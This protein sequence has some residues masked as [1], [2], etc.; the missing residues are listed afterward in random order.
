M[1]HGNDRSDGLNVK[2]C[3]GKNA[4]ISMNN[5]RTTTMKGN[6]DNTTDA[7]TVK[8]KSCINTAHNSAVEGKPLAC[9]STSSEGWGHGETPA[10]LERLAMA[11]PQGLIEGEKGLGN[12]ERIVCKLVL[13]DQKNS[14]LCHRLNF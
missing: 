7:L 10:R 5:K 3:P 2:M 8:E 9:H 13:Y 11:T 4:I 1:K 12:R 14:F 6:K